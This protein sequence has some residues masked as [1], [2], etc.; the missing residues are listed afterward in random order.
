M[1]GI[2]I[3]EMPCPMLEILGGLDDYYPTEPS[4]HGIGLAAEQFFVEDSSH[5]GLVLNRRVHAKLLPQVL[6][7]LGCNV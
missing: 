2:L 1:R 4:Y 5:W 3:E 6:D 7:W